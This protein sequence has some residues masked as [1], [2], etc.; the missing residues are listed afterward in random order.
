MEASERAELGRRPIAGERPAG[1][2][3]TDD[4]DFEALRSEVLK[5]PVREETD[6]ARVVE[7]G[8]EILGEK[9]K[10]VTAATY[11]AVGLFAT[12]GYPGLLDGLRIVEG[13]LQ[14]HWEGAFP[15]V[16][17]RR[18]GRANALE[19]LAERVAAWT[20]QREATPPEA[21]AVTACLQACTDL[22]KVIGERFEDLDVGMGSATRA[23]RA[24]SERL[25][26]EAPPP[27]AEA[28]ASE[29]RSGAQSAEGEAAPEA[30]SAPSTAA[31]RA[32][33]PTSARGL[34]VSSQAD[35]QTLV[36]KSA[37]FL[38][39][40]EPTSPTPYRLVRALRFGPITAA[41]AATEGRTPLV[42]PSAERRSGL[43]RLADSG[44]WAALLEAAESAFR[45]GSPLWLDL[46]RYTAR[47]LEGL[48]ARFAAAQR[49]VVEE[50]AALLARAPELPQLRF[51][52]DTPFASPETAEWLAE[53]VASA[54]APAA[55]PERPS[56]AP[57]SA[58]PA[59]EAELESAR[60]TARE[61][62][63]TGDPGAALAALREVLAADGSQRSRFLAE[64]ELAGLLA[65]AGRERMALPLL[66]ALDEAVSRHRLEEW[67]PE[68]GRRVLEALYRLRRKRARQRGA[69]ADEASRAEA[70]YDRLCR[71]DPG[72]AARLD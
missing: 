60:R 32:A 36:F 13:L 12:E 39:S 2:P 1:R 46:Q 19:W 52:D 7:L 55:A 45:E 53:A 26:A 30:P 34:E 31:A 6:W 40:Q 3:V 43:Q 27:E 20:S 17:K 47:A 65:D 15:P 22:D 37:A 10:D 48:G 44:D 63:R 58:E 62:V 14:E 28:P 33:A 59:A 16:P 38:R 8:T 5:D 9:S 64:L 18:R 66:E 68:L 51:R 41:P 69:P 67:E 11:L 21:E 35:A 4:P 49:A 57:A 25:A 24:V 61:R 23:L 70:L 50:L 42:P 71:L 29:A 54:G 72:A 56:P